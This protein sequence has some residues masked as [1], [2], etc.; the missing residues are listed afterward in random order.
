MRSEVVQHTV[1]IAK[2]GYQS[3]YQYRLREM[4]LLHIQCIYANMSKNNLF[5]NLFYFWKLNFYIS[6][7]VFK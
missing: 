7:T 4:L 6:Y 3:F 1:L 2:T 5:H